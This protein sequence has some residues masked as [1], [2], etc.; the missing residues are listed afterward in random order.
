MLDSTVPVDSISPRDVGADAPTFPAVAY[1]SKPSVFFPSGCVR[2]SD[3]LRSAA[4]LSYRLKVAA[5]LAEGRD[6]A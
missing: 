4:L 3:S 5:R 6:A 1:A 2:L